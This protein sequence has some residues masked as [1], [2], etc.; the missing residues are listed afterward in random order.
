MARKVL[1]GLN[2]TS[3]LQANGLAGSTGQLLISQGSGSAPG[4]T[5]T[6][7]LNNPLLTS[8]ST[9]GGNG[10]EGGQINFARVSDGATYWYIDS[11]GTAGT[12][13]GSTPDL[14]IIENATERFR[15]GS[16]GTIYVNGNVGTSGY[17]LTSNGPSSPASWSPV[18]GGS[19]FTGGTLN[20][21]L[22][23]AAGSST[24]SPI[25]FL[26]G[27]TSSS[28]L[29][30]GVMEWSSGNL[31]FTNN[32][33]TSKGVL[34]TEHY[35][36]I[37][38]DAGSYTTDTSVS[39]FPALT[40]GISLESGVRYEFEG[41]FILRVA[42]TFFSSGTTTGTLNLGFALPTTTYAHAE[43]YSTSGTSSTFGAAT[44]T[45]IFNAE[46][47]ALTTNGVGV[48]TATRSTAG[49]ATTYAYVRVKGHLKTSATGYFN[50]KVTVTTTGLGSSDG[51]IYAGSWIAIKKTPE[52][53]GTWS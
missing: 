14:R 11:Y 31:L 22:T 46:T 8:I 3:E 50:P 42:A 21:T 5:S 45:M 44:D 13:S 7:N 38:A 53:V 23:L 10:A 30:A 19:S 35:Y 34:A 9:V 39:L 47:T 2:L 33:T 32:T 4:W 16:G 41:V 40:N 25:A 18:S 1:T 12:P 51:N 6:P 43:F 28:A 48:A 29:A 37:A 27:A 20:S 15:F 36:S 49:T 26:N 17:V 24:V 52:T